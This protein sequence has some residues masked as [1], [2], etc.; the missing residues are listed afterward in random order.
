M[1]WLLPIGSSLECEGIPQP[2]RILRGLGGGGQGQ[3]F[4]A[5]LG[6]EAMAVK[7]YYPTAIQ[8]DPGLRR[9]LEESIRATSPND[10]FLW[11]IA[12]LRPTAA[13]AQ[14]IQF[15]EPGFGYLMRLRPPSYVAANEHYAGR[16]EISLQ[17]V[18]RCCF[19]L[20]EAFHALHSRGFCYK[21]ISLGNLFLDPADGQALICDNDNVDVIGRNQGGVVGTWGFM[22][23]EVGL[24]L[25]RP[26]VQSDLFSLAVLIFRLL[27]RHD[28]LRGCR[29][30]TIPCLDLQ[31]KRRL[32]A[33]EPLF[34]FDP[35][36]PGNRP[37]SVE[38]PAPLITW[39]I[40]PP[41]LQE[42]FVQTFG[43]GMRQSERRALTGQWAQ[44]LAATLDRRSCCPH[45]GQEN[46][47]EPRQE[48][49]C[50]SCGLVFA[51]APRLVMANGSVALAA[52]NELHPHHFDPLRAESLRRP[53]GRVV[54]H[55]SRPG[56]LGLSN[57]DRHPWQATLSSGKELALA[58]G[59]SCNLSL[60]VRLST[61]QGPAELQR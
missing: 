36:D 42:L 6:G 54:A 15:P 48:K 4:E 46:F 50:W 45:C 38:H 56:V 12:L 7:W 60:V 40:Y 29:E 55:P 53:L 25:A 59:E 14:R 17:A 19:D 35:L 1:A 2:L 27:T 26:D 52:G 49:L 23:P 41:L 22:A 32:Y 39:P 57:L 13:A 3:V 16:L 5:E 61:P 58:P 21:D 30:L 10:R 34:I 44:A 8:R 51:A 47:P 20:A 28:P 33:E 18:L 43:P 37:D 11:P 9:R 24:G 31:A